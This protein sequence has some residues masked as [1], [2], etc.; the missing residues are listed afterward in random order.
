MYEKSAGYFSTELSPPFAHALLPRAKLIVTL[1][2]PALR[3]YSWYQ[4]MY[5]HNDTAAKTTSFYDVITSETSSAENQPLKRLRERCLEPGFYYQHLRAWLTFYPKEQLLVI[6]GDELRNDPASV[7]DKI[8]LFLKPPN[9]LDYRKKLRFNSK[10]G[11]FCPLTEDGRHRCLGRGKGRKY[12]DMD[13]KSYSWLKTFYSRSNKLL[14]RYL[15]KMGYP[16]P[17][18]LKDQH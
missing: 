18:W 16:L 14:S 2:D 17:Q 10:K 1:T 4:H 8:Q 15:E 7:M 5:A 13:T 6:D 9:I 3:A 11:F 12:D